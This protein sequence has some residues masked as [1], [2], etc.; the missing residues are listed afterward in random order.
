MEGLLQS[1]KFQDQSKQLEICLLSGH[2]ARKKGSGINWQESG[3]LWWQGQPIERLDEN[4]YQPFLDEVYRSL[5]LKNQ[6]AGQDLLATGECV[7]THKTGHSN[8]KE[9]IL[10]EREFIVR[11]TEIRS[12]LKQQLFGEIE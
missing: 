12:I 3:L 1:L 7:L 2:T 9:T 4:V 5:F 6:E 11:L 10:T 8:P